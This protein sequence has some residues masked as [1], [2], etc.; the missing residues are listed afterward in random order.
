MK[1]RLQIFSAAFIVVFAMLLGQPPF[2]S[3]S[4]L[5]QPTDTDDPG[6]EMMVRI[7]CAKG[8]CSMMEDDASMK[9]CKKKD[10]DPFVSCSIGC[11]CYLVENFFSY[12]LSNIDIKQKLHVFDD[13]R[14]SEAVFECWQP[15]EMIS[16]S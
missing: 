2:I 13:N 4:P 9:D 3:L 15:P 6:C 1:M 5:V 12:S 14:T 10:C 16:H 7:S 8:S 11:S